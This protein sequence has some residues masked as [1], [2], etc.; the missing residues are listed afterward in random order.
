MDGTVWCR[1]VQIFT[2]AIY[3]GLL[4]YISMNLNPAFYHY[5]FISY[6]FSCSLYLFSYKAT[7]YTLYSNCVC[8]ARYMSGICGGSIHRDW[9]IISLVISLSSQPKGNYWLLLPV[10]LSYR[11]VFLWLLMLINW[12]CQQPFSCLTFISKIFKHSSNL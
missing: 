4:D 6:V 5:R 7:Q 10:M 3:D 8:N 1:G 11:V 12:E 9:S 2:H